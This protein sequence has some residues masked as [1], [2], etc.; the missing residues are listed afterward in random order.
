MIDSLC[1]E[2]S[3]CPS[4]HHLPKYAVS[5]GG[6]GLL[7]SVEPLL[8][9]APYIG[10]KRNLAARIVKSIEAIPSSLLCGA[11][12]RNGRRVFPAPVRVPTLVDGEI[13]VQIRVGPWFSFTAEDI[14]S[15]HTMN[16]ALERSPI[17]PEQAMGP[18][19]AVPRSKRGPTD[20][21]LTGTV[22]MA[23]R[24][25]VRAHRTVRRRGS[26]RLQDP[27]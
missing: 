27:K 21:R 23:L 25:S 10:G 24:P 19:C 1:P 18:R 4:R 5:P 8:D 2:P 20:R 6:I 7:R 11:V 12:R 17:H 13:A 9:A 3:R 14:G 22:W 15:A 26:R 16:E